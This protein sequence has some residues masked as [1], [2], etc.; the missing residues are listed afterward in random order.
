[1]ARLC[2]ETARINV[3]RRRHCISARSFIV[4]A[5][6]FSSSTDRLRASEHRDQGRGSSLPDAQRRRRRADSPH[7]ARPRRRRSRCQLRARAR[8]VARRWAKSSA[9]WARGQCCISPRSTGC[10]RT[11]TPEPSEPSRR[12][13]SAS[14]SA[15]SAA[16]S[17]WAYRRGSEAASNTSPATAYSSCLRADRSPPV[18]LDVP[19]L[20]GWPQMH[21]RLSFWSRTTT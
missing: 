2:P 16:T 7:S 1:M 18:P 5:Y 9:P 11:G 3:P 8:G 6:R 15:T 4:A 12:S 14:E 20:V 17:P 10:R 21:Q 13:V 19:S